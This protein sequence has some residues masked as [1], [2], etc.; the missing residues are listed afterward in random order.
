M[1]TPEIP[2]SK[3]CPKCNEL[4]L[5]SGFGSNKQRS[6]GS[7]LYCL[8]CLSAAAKARRDL[9]KRISVV[10]QEG[11]KKCTRCKRLRD[12]Q[13]FHVDRCRK[14]GRQPT[15]KECLA[16][17]QRIRHASRT[18]RYQAPTGKK[19]CPRCK[20]CLDVSDFHVERGSIDGTSHLCKRCN[21]D[22]HQALRMEVFNHYCQGSPR[23]M[24]CGETHPYFLSI[25]H[26]HGG[27]A[28]HIK[29]LKYA[30][31]YR[32]LKRNGFPEGYQ[33]LCHNCNQAK[34]FYGICP[35][36]KKD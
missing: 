16:D 20:R 33:I 7:T 4:K 28:K 27:G 6:D 2:E 36:Q 21:A 18:A 19:N 14:D 25:D 10:A 24:C 34:G 8:T 26:I 9:Y 13:A 1:D 35:H 5:L 30:T 17:L 3:L 11:N 22:R 29:A 12:I 15:C 32:F 23:C 31:L